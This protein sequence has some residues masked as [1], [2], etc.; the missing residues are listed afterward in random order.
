VTERDEKDG[1]WE[2][3]WNQSAAD[4]GGGGYKKL[5]LA[6]R[7][8]LTAFAAS[9]PNPELIKGLSAEL[10]NWTE[11]LEADA[12]GEDQQ[13][14]GRQIRLEGRG[15][16]TSPGI[17]YTHIGSV[18]IRGRVRF[19]R[20]FLGSNGAAHGGAIAFVFDEAAGR[21]SHLDG[22]STARTAYLR[23]TFRAIVPIDID[24]E[25]EGVIERE[26][27]RKRFLRLNIWHGNVLCAE[28]EVLMIALE[29]GQ[30]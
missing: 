7:R 10:Q 16:V 3:V 27:R 29:S 20:F 4:Y 15:Q 14:Y 2:T 30:A 19:D 17:V 5:V 25:I 23:T 12:V 9:R 18:H 1:I 24:V 13:V 21:L 8:F 26:E 11:G 22:R 28:A 6:L